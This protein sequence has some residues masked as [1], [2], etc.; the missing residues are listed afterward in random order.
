MHSTALVCCYEEPE[1]VVCDLIPVA[2][3][4]GDFEK[5]ID[6]D[7]AKMMVEEN[8]VEAFITERGVVE[9]SD[10]ENDEQFF[11]FVRKR[12]DKRQD[13]DCNYAI[14]NIKW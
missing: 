6:Y 9:P 14:Y 3:E 13:A 7:K 12:I 2:I 1:S 11:A 10:F 8:H 4:F 5:T